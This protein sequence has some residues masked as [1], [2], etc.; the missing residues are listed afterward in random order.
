[1]VDFDDDVDAAA[2]ASGWSTFRGTVEGGSSPSASGREGF[3]AA[4]CCANGA[5]MLAHDLFSG[6]G[7][8]G[9]LLGR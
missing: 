6:F 1:M 9:R 8:P 3:V 2:A 7:A 4:R 5:E